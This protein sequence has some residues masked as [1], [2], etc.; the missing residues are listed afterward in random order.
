MDLIRFLGLPQKVKC[1]NCKN[2]ID[3]VFEDY[4]VDC[5][6]P[7][8][9]DNDGFLTLDVYCNICDH[10]TEIKVECKVV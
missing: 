10:R 9:I 5:G 4:D 3:S 6:T 7:D 2:K 1:S 8:A